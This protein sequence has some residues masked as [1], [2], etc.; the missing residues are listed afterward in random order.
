M[1]TNVAS[2]LQI[3]SDCRQSSCSFDKN[4]FTEEAIRQIGL[5]LPQSLNS[6]VQKRKAEY[7]AGRF[8]ARKALA[9][10]GYSLDED[11]RVGANREPLWP[12]G[13]VGSITHT[14]GYASAVVAS[15]NKIRAV[16][17]D[18]ESWIDPERADNISRQ[19]LTSRENFAEYR[20]LF[21]SPGQY[22]TCVFSA[23]ESLF[24]CLFPLVNRFFDFHAAVITPLSAGSKACGEFR[25]ELLED[26]NAEFCTGYSGIGSYC[27]CTNFVH[28]AVIL[29]A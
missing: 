21:E 18:S 9:Q 25:F 22:L 28:T 8:C 1:I 2:P 10:L 24:K 29:K 12:L 19:I 6:A 7:A 17:I 23:K 20:H 13:Y 5:T 3:D 16:G 27:S 26:L 15:L 11:I 14:H 4:L